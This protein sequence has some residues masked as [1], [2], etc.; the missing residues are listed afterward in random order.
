MVA[1]PAYEIRY[2]MAERLFPDFQPAKSLWP[3]H[4]RLALWLALE[5]AIVLTGLAEHRPDL[6]QRLRSIQCL[7]ELGLS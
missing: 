1:P 4:K 7:L 5:L 2:I 3:V 6:P